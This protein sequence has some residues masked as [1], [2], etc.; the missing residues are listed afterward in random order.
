MRLFL[1]LPGTI[2]FQD[3]PWDFLTLFSNKHCCFYNM[4]KLLDSLIVRAWYWNQENWEHCHEAHP[5]C[6]IVFS[7]WSDIVVMYDVIV[8]PCGLAVTLLSGVEP[9]LIW[10]AW[11]KIFFKHFPI[12]II[13]IALDFSYWDLRG[14]DCNNTQFWDSTET[15]R[16]IMSSF[17]WMWSKFWAL[18]LRLH[19]DW[20]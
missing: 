16:G 2:E 15:V 3:F 7:F 5:K 18:E 12:P 10:L 6:G 11:T 20:D 8:Y 17:F 9:C 1:E 19:F 4:F 14:I 13:E